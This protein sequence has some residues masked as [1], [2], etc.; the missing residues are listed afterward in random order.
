MAD[1]TCRDIL[2]QKHHRVQGA[3]W[4]TIN[5]PEAMN[6]FTGET[7]AEM[8]RAVDDAN[9]D[10]NVGVIVLT[11]AGDRAFCAGGDVKWLAEYKENAG[12]P[13]FDHA[14]IGTA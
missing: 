13:D 1:S 11:G 12:Q 14:G 4:I 10:D 2:F 7:L 8:R 3:A 5:R 6:S 9:A